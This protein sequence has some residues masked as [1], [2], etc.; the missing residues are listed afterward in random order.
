MVSRSTSIS[1][2]FCYKTSAANVTPIESGRRP[3][4]QF[5]S[6]RYQ[7]N[8]LRAFLSPS[9]RSDFL[10]LFSEVAPCFA[11]YE[12]FVNNVVDFVINQAKIK[13]RSGG[14]D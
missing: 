7:Y 3:P 10:E 12:R 8:S 13:K 9:D 5:Q 14:C 11:M 6:A 4:Q 1:C 2:R